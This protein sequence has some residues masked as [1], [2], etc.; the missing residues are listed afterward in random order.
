M[1]L[2]TDGGRIKEIPLTA[3]GQESQDGFDHGKEVLLLAQQ[4]PCS[5]LPPPLG[6]GGSSQVSLVPMEREDSHIGEVLRQ[7]AYDE[8]VGSEG[9][10]GEAASSGAPPSTSPQARLRS[11]LARVS[12][13]EYL[14]FTASAAALLLPPLAAAGRGSPSS[15]PSSSPSSRP[16]SQSCSA[17]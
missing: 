3:P 10:E 1:I 6:D 16:S 13:E 5:V 17:L 2:F 15:C 8:E 14:S 4:Q 11:P 12:A 9:F 7:I